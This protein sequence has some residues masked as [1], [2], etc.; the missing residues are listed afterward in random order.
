MSLF[1]TLTSSRRFC[2][3]TAA[4]TAV[5]PSITSVNHFRAI[6]DYYF[7]LELGLQEDRVYGPGS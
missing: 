6:L 2:F 1:S 5:Y 4:K 7:G 3:Q